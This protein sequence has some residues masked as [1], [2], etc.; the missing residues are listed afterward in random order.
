VTKLKENSKASTIKYAIIWG[1]ISIAAYAVLFLNE[2]TV[3]D[4]FSRGGYFAAL[5]IATAFIFS[6]VHGSFSNYLV[7]AMG[8]KAIKH[9]KGGH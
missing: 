9:G 1:I 7:E 8:F 5:V 2:K 4:Y 3:T 6:I